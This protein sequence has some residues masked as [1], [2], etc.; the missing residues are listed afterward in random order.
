MHLSDFYLVLVLGFASSLH[1]VQMCGPI[2]LTYSVSLNADSTRRPLIWAH[3]AYNAGRILTYMLLGA[4]A[5][6]AGGTVGFAAR[7][8]GAQ[9]AGAII[10]GAAMVVVGVLMIVSRRSPNFLGKFALP[11]RILRPVGALLSSRSVSSKF[12]LGLLLG[13]LPCGVVYV[14]LLQAVGMGTPVAGAVTML[15]FGVGTSAALIAIGLG[16]SLA[17]RKLTRW[18][19]AVASVTVIV[20]GALLIVRGSMPGLLMFGGGHS[21]HHH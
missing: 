16:S 17:T 12:L 13:L 20:L 9:N 18:S 3:L 15:A 4:V 14:A 11:S 6:I 7:F 1:C 8:T 19:T 5:G 21:H 10:A 2:V